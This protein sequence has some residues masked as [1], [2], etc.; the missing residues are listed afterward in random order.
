MG[1]K[2][3]VDSKDRRNGFFKGFKDFITK[4]NIIDMAIGVI[5]G[6]AFSKIVSSLVNDIIMPPIGVLIGN[7]DF[8]D[9]VIVLKP[10]TLSATDEIITAAVTINYGS[11]IM[12]IIEFLIIAFSIYAALTLVIRRRQFIEKLE[13]EKKAQLLEAEPK[14]EVVEVVQISEE[15]LLL[16]EIRDSLQDKK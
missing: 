10:E 4:G 3:K 16:R 6:G 13:E 15:I 5:I 2:V 1:K 9:L 8:K 14:D 11:F 12:M 7:V